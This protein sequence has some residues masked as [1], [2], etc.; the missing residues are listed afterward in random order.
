MKKENICTGEIATEA[1]IIDNGDN[2]IYGQLYRPV[3]EGKHPAIILSHGYNGVHT[4][5]VHECKY[6]AQNGYIAY[7]YDFCG[8]SVRSKSTGNSTD[9]TI[10]SEKSDLL[11]V[12]DFIYGMEEVDSDNVVVFGGS[13]GGLVSALVAAERADKVSAL[14]LYFPALCIPDDWAKKYP[15]LDTVPEK[16]DFWGLMLGKGF[17]EDLKKIDVFGTIGAYEGNVL[18][19]HGDQ[20]AIVPYSYSEKAVKT[21]AHAQ[22]V[23]MEGEGH[24]FTPVADKTAVERVLAFMKE[25][26]KSL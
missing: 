11:A 14:A 24:G 10:S 16:F 1:L 12:F 26:Y 19:L 9:M 21:Y 18:I 17:V 7:A 3:G 13:Q 23:K 2:R 22:L 8:G 5:F 4:D 25:N 6:F 15:N 20:D